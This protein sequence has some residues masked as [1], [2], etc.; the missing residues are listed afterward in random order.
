[1]SLILYPTVGYDA[2]VSV[3]DCDAF[4][5]LNVVTAQRA[6]YSLL[7]DTDKEVYIRQATTL[8]ASKITLPSTLEKDIQDA[9]SY[10]VNASIGIDMLSADKSS[11]IKVKD[12]V[13]VVSTE[14]FA[15][16]RASNSFP[17]IVS[18]LL[19]QYGLS[20]HNALTLERS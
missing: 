11:N 6:S 8:I 1:M 7:S 9:T 19:T 5:A 20:A 13:G 15:T 10:L 14:Y 17:D 4:L 12:I 16:G 18:I 2:L 3:V